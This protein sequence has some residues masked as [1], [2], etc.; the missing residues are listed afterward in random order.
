[1][2][3]K[4]YDKEYLGFNGFIWFMGVVEDILD[5]LKTGRVK[6]RCLE[7]H[8]ENKQEVP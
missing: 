4:N 2:A 1:M 8:S 7:W 5:P 3:T 6:V